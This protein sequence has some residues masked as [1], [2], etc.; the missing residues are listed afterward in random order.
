MSQTCA[1]SLIKHTNN[2]PSG[3]HPFTHERPPRHT[4][5]CVQTDVWH[6]T[7]PSEGSENPSSTTTTEV[8]SVQPKCWSREGLQPLFVNQGTVQAAGPVISWEDW[9]LQPSLFFCISPTLPCSHDASRH[10]SKEECI[11]TSCDYYVC[12]FNLCYQTLCG[13]LWH[14]EHFTLLKIPL[15]SHYTYWGLVGNE[16]GRKNSPDILNK[17]WLFMGAAEEC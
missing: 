16:E 13:C 12:L 3:M 7:R 15:Q 1:F 9:Y 11:A 10:L 4:G 6:Q 5:E 17:V 8:G 14:K 2:P